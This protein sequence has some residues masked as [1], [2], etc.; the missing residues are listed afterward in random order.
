MTG[1]SSWPVRVLA[2]LLRPV[3][4]HIVEQEKPRLTLHPGASPR[5][6]LLLLDRLNAAVRNRARIDIVDYSQASAALDVSADQR[7][8]A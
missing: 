7:G 1:R 8:A 4:L 2:R 3:V 5:E 6:V